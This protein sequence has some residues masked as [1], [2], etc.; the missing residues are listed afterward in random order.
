MAIRIWAEFKWT[1]PE[2]SRK[3]FTAERNRFVDTG[4]GRFVL[5][6]SGFTKATTEEKVIAWERPWYVSD[7]PG[8]NLPRPITE[9][10]TKTKTLDLW[11][12]ASLVRAVG[13][14]LRTAIQHA[15]GSDWLSD[16]RLLSKASEAL[17]LPQSDDTSGL[18]RHF[19]KE[20]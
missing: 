17:G 16:Y 14:E 19:Q 2:G 8:E 3:R 5:S 1:M 9:T 10:I 12:S 13:G 7:N 18:N 15:M 6:N 4:A 20:H 11:R